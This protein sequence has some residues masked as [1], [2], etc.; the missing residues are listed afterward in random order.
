MKRLLML[1]VITLVITL[2]LAA[3]N[4]VLL[5]CNM[6]SYAAQL[7]PD[8]NYGT[9]RALESQIKFTFDGTNRTNF[10][11]KIAYMHYALPSELVGKVKVLGARYYFYIVSYKGYS[12]Y[13]IGEA[14]YTVGLY[15]CLSSWDENTITY[16]N[17]PTSSGPPFYEIAGPKSSFL[18]SGTQYFIIGDYGLSKLQEI[19]DTGSSFGFA[20]Y[21][22]VSPATSGTLQ[23]GDYELRLAIGSRESG[24]KMTYI[25]MD[26]ELKTGMMVNGSNVSA[27][28]LG[29]VKARYR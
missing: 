29:E 10:D 25:A 8:T 17:Q 20:W 24:N 4:K 2:A 26:Y 21:T 6:D 5:K 19:A 3:P 27:A 22:D 1:I 16:N 18:K 13:K 11:D 15:P 14:V 23:T 12:P 9:Q 28:T 7:S